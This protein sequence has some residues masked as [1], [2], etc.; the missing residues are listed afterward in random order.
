MH[1][2]MHK[3]SSL[4]FSRLTSSE[5]SLLG[6]AHL[7]HF[8]APFCN[9]CPLS[10][11]RQRSANNE[12]FV[13]SSSS[14]IRRPHEGRLGRHLGHP[15]S[16]HSIAIGTW[17]GPSVPT[18]HPYATGGAS[19]EAPGDSQVTPGV[20][21]ARGGS[22]EVF[23]EVFQTSPKVRSI[24]GANYEP[25]LVMEPPESRSVIGG[26]VRRMPADSRVSVSADLIRR[27]RGG[28]HARQ[29]PG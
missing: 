13:F 7:L 16:H 8:A 5:V 19:G 28:F 20:T 29:R 18:R 1:V 3:A 10:P 27:S 23:W 6:E 4:C 14:R 9:L 22:G 25:K 15:E 17:E 2:S 11:V 24:L 26:S 21:L 12:S